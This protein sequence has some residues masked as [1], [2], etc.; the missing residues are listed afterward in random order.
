MVWLLLL[1]GHQDCLKSFEVTTHIEVVKEVLS[2]VLVLHE[3]L[4]VLEHLK[5]GKGQPW[6]GPR[7]ELLPDISLISLLLQ[8]DSDSPWCWHIPPTFSTS[9]CHWVFPPIFPIS[10]IPVSPQTPL[11]SSFPWVKENYLIQ[12]ETFQVLTCTSQLRVLQQ[13][14]GLLPHEA[15]QPWKFYPK[16][17]PVPQG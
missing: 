9:Q 10:G 5:R 7:N 6:S 1:Q 12:M 13:G 17:S 16:I 15:E 2:G 11:K 3:E 4:Q 14:V 8:M